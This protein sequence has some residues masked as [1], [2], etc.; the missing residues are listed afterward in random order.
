[1]HFMNYDT[2]LSPVCLLLV[3]SPEGQIVA[4][5]LHDERRILVTVFRHV[6][7]LCD[8]IF[9]GGAGHLAC[10]VWVSQHLILKHRVV[11]SKAKTNGMRYSQVLLSNI[12]CLLVCEPR[13]LRCFAF[14]ITVTEFSDVTV[15]VG[16]HLLVEDL[17]LPPC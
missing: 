8:R 2:S 17:R 15:V 9:E 11:Q 10:L 13:I 7:K 5:Q 14:G 16:L 12:R 3:G 4:E 6:V 1:M